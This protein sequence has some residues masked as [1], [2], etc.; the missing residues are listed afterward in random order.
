MRI[1]KLSLPLSEADRQNLQ[2][3]DKVLLS[4]TLYTTRDKAHKRMLEFLERG[5]KLPFDL[6][7]QAIF[8]A[9][10]S[11]AKIG[12]TC[13]VIGPTTS[14]RMD[15]YTP[16]FLEEGLRVMIGKGQRSKD[17]EALIRKHK[18]VYLAAVGGAAA[19][20]RKRVISCECIAWQD[21]GA[22]GIFRLEVRDFPC[23][24]IIV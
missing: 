9:G 17:I 4:G 16:R 1:V 11:P 23:Y 19:F 18:A 7:N 22:E 14:G 6:K 8:Y 21:L 13:G 5:E 3:G 24:V 12:Q 15:V 10:P 2:A 20:L